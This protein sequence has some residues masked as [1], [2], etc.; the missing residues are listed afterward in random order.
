M[1]DFFLF[2][3][4]VWCMCVC[5]S[6][7]FILPPYAHLPTFNHPFPSFHLLSF[8]PPPPLSLVMPFPWRRPMNA[9]EP[10]SWPE[11]HLPWTHL[12]HGATTPCV[13][14]NNMDAISPLPPM[15]AIDVILVGHVI[16]EDQEVQIG[17][18]LLTSTR[19]KWV[20]SPLGGHISWHLALYYL[21]MF[22]SYT[23]LVMCV[24]HPS[25]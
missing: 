13:S 3:S 8:L 4:N 19:P 23:P 7:V 18:E 16:E 15:S 1:L 25:L 22:L 10:K 14:C 5:S 17:V 2:K 6:S 11:G 24:V 21:G 20:T 12:W 9:A